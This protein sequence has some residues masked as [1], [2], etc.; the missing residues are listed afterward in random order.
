M[1]LTVASY[2]HSRYLGPVTHDF[3]SDSPG[4]RV[5]AFVIIGF[6]HQARGLP[7]FP[8]P[9]HDIT[10]YDL[11]EVH[12]WTSHQWNVNYEM[13]NTFRERLAHLTGRTQRDYRQ[14]PTLTRDAPFNDLIDFPDNQGVLGPGAAATLASH[15][16]HYRDQFQAENQDT[17]WL[18]ALYDD[19]IIG[20]LLAKRDG[21]I[22]YT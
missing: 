21:L 9:E 12:P 17:S 7:S 13:H 1:A 8:W 3:N 5:H 2:P 10:S 4:H 20:S 14:R 15:F 18:V 22:K 6:E 19:W 16:T 11:Y